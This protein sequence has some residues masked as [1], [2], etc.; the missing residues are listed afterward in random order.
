MGLDIF[1]IK[2]RIQF[3]WV[4]LEWDREK[5]EYDKNTMY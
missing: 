3:G 2:I 1:V 4:N 5:D